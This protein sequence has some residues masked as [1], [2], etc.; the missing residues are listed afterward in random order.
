MKEAEKLERLLNAGKKHLKDQNFEKALVNFISAYEIDKKNPDT[1]YLLGITY[2]RIGK[3]ES[4]LFSFDQLLSTDISYINKI[5]TRMIMGYIYTIMDD[6]DQALEHF[7]SIADAGFESAQVFAAIGYIM[8]CK[9]NFK[10]AC[11]N[12]YR[13]IDID[14]KNAN[15]RNSLGYIYAEAE[16]NLKE[17]LTE[18]KK[19]VAMDKEN[20]AYLDSLG[21]VYYKLGNVSQA[22]SYLKK[23]SK[24]AP[25]NEEIKT[26]LSIVTK[27]SP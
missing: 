16:I 12:L 27:G 21:W 19:A 2:T 23:A 10:Q 26:H 17:A 24:M 20:P 6:F 7:K 5:H 18:C 25:D 8:D 11:M 3:Y 15:A 13:A 22:K 4:A 14:P 9:G 1:L